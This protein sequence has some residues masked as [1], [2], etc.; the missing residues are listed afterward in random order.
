[1]GI[2]PISPLRTHVEFARD[3]GRRAGRVKPNNVGRRPIK[4]DDRAIWSSFAKEKNVIRMKGLMKTADGVKL[5]H[6]PGQCFCK[7][8]TITKVRFQLCFT[9]RIGQDIPECLALA[10]FGPWRKTINKSETMGLFVPPKT[11]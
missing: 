7:S 2:N 5:Q 4:F 9:N 3:S 1:M 8:Q 6:C 10:M 11:V